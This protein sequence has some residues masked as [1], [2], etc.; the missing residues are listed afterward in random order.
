LRIRPNQT[1]LDRTFA[2]YAY[3]SNEPFPEACALCG[4]RP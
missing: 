3:R 2:R 4:F 1:K